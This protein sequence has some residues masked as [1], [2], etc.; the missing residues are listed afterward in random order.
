MD[1]MPGASLEWG[2]NTVTPMT[3]M[4]LVRRTGAQFLGLV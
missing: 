2:L 4:F 1:H 3:L